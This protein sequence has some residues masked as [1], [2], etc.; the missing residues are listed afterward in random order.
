[1]AEADNIKRNILLV[2]DDNDLR[3]LY[4]DVLKDAGYVVEQASDGDLGYELIKSTKWD[5]LLLDVML[6]GKDG[7]SILKAIH[8]EPELKRGPIVLL[9]NLDNEELVRDA[10]SMGADG[11]LIK[12]ELTPDKI[13]N[14]INHFLGNE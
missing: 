6:P 9:T 12:T 7:M 10:Y 4:V 1:M 11:Y 8:Q 14:E 3:P 2:E 5:L 13:V